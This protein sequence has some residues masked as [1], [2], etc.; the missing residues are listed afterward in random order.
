MK[1]I[2]KLFLLLVVILGVVGCNSEE[3]VELLSQE[4]LIKYVTNH[5]DEAVEFIDMDI[6]DDKNYVYTFKL[7]DRNIN[8]KVRDYIYDGGL[9]IDGAQ[10]FSD[11]KHEIRMDDYV[12]QIVKENETK[13][14]DILQKYGF[15]EEYYEV[16]GSHSIK[17]KDYTDIANLSKYLVELDNLYQFNIR[18][19]NEIALG[20]VDLIDILSF[21]N[22]SMEEIEF[23]AN[24]N[25]RL[26]ES[27]VYKKIEEKYIKQLKNFNLSDENISKEVWNKY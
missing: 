3:D 10:F 24:K 11:Y 19:V 5:I 22:F 15:Q 20:N 8:F 2:G 17:V 26:K 12:V 25:S 6:Q 1:R 18:N 16:L 4:E 27:E 14:L 7:V 21:A 23:S 9:N 13:R